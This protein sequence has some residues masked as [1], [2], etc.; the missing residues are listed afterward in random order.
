MSH[1]H[2][3]SRQYSDHS[4][5]AT[6]V[7]F[8]LGVVVF[9]FVGQAPAVTTTA[10]KPINK[11]EL[12]LRRPGLPDTVFRVA[13][14]SGETS[15]A[16]VEESAPFVAG[17]KIVSGKTVFIPGAATT[18][19]VMCAAR[20]QIL[21]GSNDS[22]VY[23]D[24]DVAALMSFEWVDAGQGLVQRPIKKNI[25]ISETVRLGRDV[26][27]LRGKDDVTVTLAPVPGGG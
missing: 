17:R 13:L 24:V 4:A 6:R 25:K 11:A 18:S 19:G 7:R 20:Q 26:V 8:F 16:R 10:N 15:C 23:V 3:S 27:T 14:K 2:P 12:T 21:L 9:L 22:M 5:R 1:H